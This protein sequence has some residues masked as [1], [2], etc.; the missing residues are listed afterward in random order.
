M[1]KISACITSSG[2][3][4]VMGL[5]GKPRFG[6]KS[7]GIVITYGNCLGL[8]KRTGISCRIRS[9]SNG[10]HGVMDPRTSKFANASAQFMP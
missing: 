10:I 2:M 8:S 6:P 1:A 5:F 9:S 3:H 7:T 4:V